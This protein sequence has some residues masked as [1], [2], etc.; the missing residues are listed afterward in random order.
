M[1]RAPPN[2]AVDVWRG[3]ATASERSRLPAGSA[4]L[5]ASSLHL[6]VST[7]GTFAELSCLARVMTAVPWADLREGAIPPELSPQQVPG[8]A[9][10][11]L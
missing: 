4:R 2:L 7:T 8:D 6:P 11:R 5:G 3:R 1:L 9:I 10:W